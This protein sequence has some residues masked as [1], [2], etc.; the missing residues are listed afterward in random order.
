MAAVMEEVRLVWIRSRF[1]C[2]P[3]RIVVLLQE[4]CNLFIQLVV[5]HS[6]PPLEQPNVHMSYSGFIYTQREAALCPHLISFC[7]RAGTSCVGRR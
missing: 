3:C 5:S 6:L 4:I 2:K 7:C 1:Y